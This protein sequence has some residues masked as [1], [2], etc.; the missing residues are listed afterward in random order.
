M[1]ITFQINYR[2]EFGQR[3]CLIESGQPVLGWT[4]Q[5]PLEMRCEGSDFWTASVLLDAAKGETTYRY[6]IRLQ[7]GGY[8]Y[9]VAK[10]KTLTLHKVGPCPSLN[11]K[12]IAELRSI[13]SQSRLTH[14][15]A[16]SFMENN[17]RI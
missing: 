14:S 12:A 16:C 3:L 5:R 13:R 1:N 4:E 11:G 6:A 7:E 10:K 8:I 9:E 15:E 2:A 17:S